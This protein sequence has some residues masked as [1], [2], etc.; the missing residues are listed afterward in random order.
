[1]YDTRIERRDREIAVYVYVYLSME[2][3]FGGKRLSRERGLI[4]YTRLSAVSS[5]ATRSE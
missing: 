2:M 3:C 5:W 1:M 4:L